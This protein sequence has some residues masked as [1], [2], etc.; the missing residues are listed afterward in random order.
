M[1]KNSFKWVFAVLIIATASAVVFP[2]AARAMAFQQPVVVNDATA[3]QILSATVRLVMFFPAE[4]SEPEAGESGRYKAAFGLGTLTA[5]EQSPVIVT[6]DHWG[7]PMEELALVEFRDAGSSLLM[8][9]PGKTF[10]QL[11]RYRDGGTLIFEAPAGLESQLGAPAGAVVQP[12]LAKGDTVL[13]LHQQDGDT[14][15][16]ELVPAVVADVISEQGVMAFELRTLDGTP[17]IHGDSG[18]GVWLNGR[19]AGNMWSTQITTGWRIGNLIS[20]NTGRAGTGDCT[21][22]GLPLSLFTAPAS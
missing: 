1:R 7:H 8:E 2:A 15:K 5:G 16:L 11:I 20:I 10:A 22:A 3:Q 6:H 18:G 17:I 12:A 13:L 9:L 14:G 19:L 4:S 21:A